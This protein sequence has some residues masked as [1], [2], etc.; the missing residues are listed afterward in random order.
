MSLYFAVLASALVSMSNEEFS[1]S[2]APMT[3]R[4]ELIWNW[5]CSALFYLDRGDFLQRSPIRVVQAIIVL[6]NVASTIGETE[7]HANL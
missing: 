5:Y 4:K 3:A 7:R 1:L 6:G 2:E